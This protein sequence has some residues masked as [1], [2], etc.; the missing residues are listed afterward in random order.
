MEYMFLQNKKLGASVKNNNDYSKNNN[1]R[2][3]KD[4][5]SDIDN[6]TNGI[7]KDRLDAIEDR[8]DRLEEGLNKLVNHFKNMPIPKKMR[9]ER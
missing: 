7:T 9:W 5:V 6:E 8:L 3:N 4:K 1:N 2:L